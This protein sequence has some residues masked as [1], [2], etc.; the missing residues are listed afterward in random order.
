MKAD[1]LF[2][3]YQSYSLAKIS[4]LN[5]Q[6]LIALYAQNEQLS[7]LNKE[8]AK[9]NSVTQQ[10]LKNQIKEIATV[11]ASFYFY[12]TKEEVDAFVEALKEGGNF[13]DAYFA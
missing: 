5:K 3:I 11:R 4:A 10:I 9:S 1:T 6:N 2:N 12:N 13:L 8:L 7:K